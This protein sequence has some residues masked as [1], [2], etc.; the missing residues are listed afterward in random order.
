MA[1]GVHPNGA[2]FAE[3]VSIQSDGN[4]GIGTTSPSSKLTVAVNV[5]YGATT[6]SIRLIDADDDT[7]VGTE[8][9]IRFGKWINS[10]GSGVSDVASIHAG[11][12]QWGATSGLRHGYLSFYTVENGSNTEK[13]RITDS[14][15]VGIGTTSPSIGTTSPSDRLE[16]KGATAK[17]VLVLSSGDTTITGN[18][19]IG[20]INFKDY[21]ADAHAGGDQDD[22]V[23]IKAIALHETGG[24]TGLDGSTGEGYA[25]SFSTSLRPS[26]NAL[27]TV[28]ERMRIDSSGIVT[29]GTLTSGNTGQLI[30]N[31]EGGATPVAKFMSRT[32]RA[33][34]QVS[35]NDT[36]G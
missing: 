28:S 1:F 7:T 16:V 4:V 10:D 8:N 36:T 35:D 21:D 26:P 29:I 25:L 32:N 9:R 33:I 24:A 20:Q 18:D 5:I 3:Q 31:Q 13:V 34:V 14:G 6:D 19:V 12:S 11:I 23:S 2:G 22:L 15:N 17:G 27:L 30:V